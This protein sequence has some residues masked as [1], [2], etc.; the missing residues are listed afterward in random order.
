MGTTRITSSGNAA[1]SKQHAT[2]TTYA[3]NAPTT[4]GRIWS[5][6]SRPSSEAW[7]VNEHRTRGTTTSPSVMEWPTW[8]WD[9][10]VSTATSKLSASSELGRSWRTAASTT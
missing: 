1:T 8:K 7:Y 5:S 3:S 2:T 10:K 4:R 9:A 6:T